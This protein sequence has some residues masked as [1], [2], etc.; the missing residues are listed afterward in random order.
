MEMACLVLLNNKRK[1]PGLRRLSAR[2]RGFGRDIEV[3][4][5]FVRSEA[6]ASLIAIGGPR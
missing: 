5:R 6:H 4:L 2:A 3:A 1:L